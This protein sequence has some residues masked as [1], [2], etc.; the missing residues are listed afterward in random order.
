MVIMKRT[1]EYI[2]IIC[3]ILVALSLLI[4][5]II[6]LVIENKQSYLEGL[7]N[8]W[9]E[10]K[11]ELLLQLMKNISFD[12]IL[13]GVVGVVLGSFLFYYLKK[14]KH[15]FVMGWISIAL[16]GILTFFSDF[17]SFTFVFFIITGLII[18]VRNSTSKAETS[19]HTGHQ[20]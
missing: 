5:G 9:S 16:P 8:K 14:D 7:Y 2:L 15:L 19:G 17:G 4:T 1:V 11:Y 18:L 20:K 12:W 3:G 10:E 6:L 13:P